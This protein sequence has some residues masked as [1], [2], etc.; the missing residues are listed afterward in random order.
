MTTTTQPITI[1]LPYC[2]R[3]GR[4]GKLPTTGYRGAMLCTGPAG[5]IHKRTRM[6]PKTFVEVEG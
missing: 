1:Q 2:P 5:A 3:C 6:E 4:V